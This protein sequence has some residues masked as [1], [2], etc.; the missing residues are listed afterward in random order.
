MKKNKSILRR[1]LSASSDGKGF[2]LIEL[3]AVLVVLGILAA[4]AVP[5]YV[6][7]QDSAREMSAQAGINEFIARANAAFAQEV[8]S[9][10]SDPTLGS[11]EDIGLGDV[12]LLVD[13]DLGDDYVGT[14][15]ADGT[16]EITTVQGEVIDAVTHVWVLPEL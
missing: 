4:V 14:F 7:L 9:R 1:M 10:V 13:E 2:T 12:D 3:V 15:G 11:I 5:R 16:I 8:A 6:D